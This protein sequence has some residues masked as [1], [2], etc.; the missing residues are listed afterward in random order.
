MAIVLNNARKQLISMLKADLN[1]RLMVISARMQR[2]AAQS[3]RLS[4][5]KATIQNAHMQA[6]IEQGT[7]NIELSDIQN[8]QYMTAD[9][10]T[11]LSLLAIKDD[12]MEC[13]MRMIET[14]LQA[15]NAEEEEIDKT[16]NNDIKREFGIFSNS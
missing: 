3:Q 14:Q 15:L 10:D 13:E 4:E 7:E 16:M 5:E 6:L 2:T 9:I 8:I 12:D 1:H 11:E